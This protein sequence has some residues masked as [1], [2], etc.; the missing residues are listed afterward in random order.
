[1]K[2][3][4]RRWNG[5]ASRFSTE[6][7]RCWEPDPAAALAAL[8][9][10]VARITWLEALNDETQ[11]DYGREH[12]ML[13]NAR[14]RIEELEGA[15]ERQRALVAALYDHMAA[16]G[17]ADGEPLRMLLA[18]HVAAPSRE[19]ETHTFRRGSIG[20]TVC[21]DCG[22]PKARHAAPSRETE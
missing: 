11:E 5:S 15:L 7:C 17:S 16:T 4:V 18:D 3:C 20:A 22:L 12:G 10:L 1:M 19:T 21:A 13:L 9:T 8:D 2:R 6:D 14:A